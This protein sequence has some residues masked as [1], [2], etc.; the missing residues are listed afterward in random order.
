M[1]L[2]VLLSVAAIPT[3]HILSA[4]KTTIAY[5]IGDCLVERIIQ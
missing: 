4:T 1:V 2:V 5:R 3:L